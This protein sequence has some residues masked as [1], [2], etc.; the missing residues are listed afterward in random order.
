MSSC[1]IDLQKEATAISD[2]KSNRFSNDRIFLA[3]KTVVIGQF[4]NYSRW[5]KQWYQLTVPDN[6]EK[7]FNRGT[8]I[9]FSSITAVPHMVRMNAM[10][11][12]WHFCELYEIL[13]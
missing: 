9:D 13:Q 10:L 8:K 12:L 3:A 6:S 1:T 5:G 2:G 7:H 4:S 11:I